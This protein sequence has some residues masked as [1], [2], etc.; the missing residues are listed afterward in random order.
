MSAA[1]ETVSERPY[2][3]DSDHSPTFT[4]DPS[5]NLLEADI[6]MLDGLLSAAIRRLAGHD[7]LAFVE[8]VRATTKDLRK[9][10]SVEKAKQLLERLGQQNIATLRTLIRAFNIYFDLI[11]LAEQHARVRTI[12]QRILRL[13]PLP[14]TESTEA[15]LR[16]L[17]EQGISARQVDGLLQ[18]ALICP[19]FTAHPSEARRLTILEK[20][21]AISKEMDRLE[22][23]APLPRERLAALAVIEEQIE[24]FWLTDTVRNDRPTVLDEVRQGLEV[25]ENSLFEV[26]PWMY[27]D[28]E[29]S[30]KEI[31]PD[32][33][34]TVPSFLRFGTWIA[35]DRDGNPNVTH[36][37]T[38]QAVKLHQETVIGRYIREMEVLGKRLSHSGQYV[39][40]S[41]EFTDSLEN[42]AGLFPEAAYQMQRE[43]YRGQCRFISEKLR[44]TLEYLQSHDP[45]WADEGFTA[46]LGIYI[47]KDDLLADL[48]LIAKELERNHA[49][50]AL[51]PVRKMMRLVDVFGMNLL[52]LDIRQHGDR[53]RQAM[54]EIL[55]WAGVSPN[56]AKLS[57]T[58]C[59]DILTNEL[60]HNRPLIPP[61]LPF[62]AETKEVI[63]TFRTIAAVLEQQ[64]PE[65]IDT[66]I[67]SG[68][69][70]AAHL[71]EVLLLAREARLFV[72][73]AGISRLNIVPLFETLDALLQASHIMQRLLNQPIYRKHLQLRGDL[74]E[75]MI[76]Y[77]D[78]NKESGFVQSAWALYRAQHALAQMAQR[79]GISIQ[80]FHGRGGAVGRG[81]GPANRAILAQPRGSINGRLRITEQGEMIADRY[82]HPAIAERHLDQVIN[83]VLRAS[84]SPNE[85]KSD[86]T[87][88][89][90][91]DRIAEKA[92][93]HYRS[94]IYETPEF[95]QYF[96]QSTPIEEVSQL[97]IAS[98][99]AR[100]TGIGS[101][102]QLRAIP[103]VFSWMQS[104]QTLPG[105]YGLGKGIQDFLEEHPRELPALQMM[106]REWHFWRTLIDNAQ[107]IL[108]KADLT[109]ARLYADLVEDQ[110]V[111]TRI[112][113]RISEEY[114]RSVDVI[115]QITGQKELLE[116]MPILK[117]SIQRR[118]PY[119]DPMSFI[120]IVLLRRTRRGEGAPEELLTGVLES[121][122]GIASGLKNTG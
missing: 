30:L 50:A 18:H 66:Y 16:Q 91:L 84:L 93:Q 15:A 67:I 45:H 113:T 3:K 109:I 119:V 59:F 21:S 63:L 73:D 111:A 51:E 85:E 36:S 43:P 20:L 97:K 34:W 55:Q 116:Q 11:N 103:W 72:P 47:H 61:H 60:K 54:A 49:L 13:A 23:E 76:G 74:Q 69:G 29:Q 14:L 89:W 41:K 115:L 40:D 65:A 88:E 10:P 86:M 100:R 99:P 117:A 37:V 7:A 53:H 71:L 17:R 92:C 33:Q 8:E 31:Y 101:I 90:I 108:A 48:A 9:N 6:H 26:V 114:H 57:S 27:R 120:Q 102:E 19:V 46:P 82:G 70:D 35:G 28:L 75:V 94:L 42:H 83:A 122:N 58:Q 2:G 38:A 118:N 79:T 78:S 106:Y 96:Q 52:K 95:L 32:H 5:P 39:A 98:R 24:T 22:Y 112:F 44:S 4:G 107:M 81:G 68:A 12:R 1:I 121:I 110:S 62:S 64:C 56:Y 104:R 87:R 105:W 25:V 77:S 80:I